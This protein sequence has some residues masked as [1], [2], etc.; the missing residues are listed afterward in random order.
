MNSYWSKD[1]ELIPCQTQ[2]FSKGH[3]YFP[4]NYPKFLER[5]KGQYV[6][7]SKKTRYTDYIMG[8]GA[9]SLGYAYPSVN[10]AIFDQLCDGISF[11]LPH[12]LE[13]KVAAELNRIIPCAE[14][15]RFS[16]TGSEVCS[17]AVKIAR[18]Y[19]G[20]PL[21][22]SWGYHGWHDWYSVITDRDKGIPEYYET[23]I[24]QFEYNSLEK[25]FNLFQENKGRVAAV[26]M[27]PCTFTEPDHGYLNA[28]RG[29]CH[30][31][32]ALFILD[33]LVTGFRMDMGGA[34]NYF[35]VTT[36]LATFGKGMANGMPLAAVVGRKE[37]MKQCEEIFFSTTF[38]GETLSLAACLATIRE[39]S[40]ANGIDHIWNLGR[41]FQAGLRHIEGVSST[42]Y[43]CRPLLTMDNETPEL[44]SLLMQ[45]LC[46][47]RIL[48]HSGQLNFC[49]MHEEADIDYLL[50]M[51]EE[52]MA[53]IRS[54][55][56]KLVGRPAKMS[57]RRL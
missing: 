36:D 52:S 20:K 57:F 51:I 14:M 38:G 19:T 44:K 21:I 16:K 30:E 7:D 10:Q 15:V 56:A 24:R 49:L 53:E 8:L 48:I 27:E 5:G 2:T 43:P 45:E 50:V 37:I 25:L 42:G 54:G 34:Q 32:G 22:L 17:A 33:E 23:L 31:E 40:L 11:S 39:L 4:E 28:V 47:R 3:E 9:V 29:L 13:V 1:K 12:T 35:D 18:A 46:R 26:F 41:R 55:R 6:Y